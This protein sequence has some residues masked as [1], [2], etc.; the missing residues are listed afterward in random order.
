MENGGQLRQILYVSAGLPDLAPADIGQ[1]F[2][3]AQRNNSDNEVRGCFFISRAVSS[4]FSRVRPPRS[5]A[6]IARSSGIGV[7]VGS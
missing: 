6:P 4:R 2:R 3:T 5:K 1:M 7:T